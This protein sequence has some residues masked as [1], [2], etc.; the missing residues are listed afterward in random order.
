MATMASGFDIRCPN[1][2]SNGYKDSILGHLILNPDSI[3][4]A[5]ISNQGTK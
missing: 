1:I 4:D 2:E 5:P 3:L